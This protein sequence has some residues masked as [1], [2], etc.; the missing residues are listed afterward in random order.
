MTRQYTNKAMRSFFG[1]R[2]G[3]QDRPQDV[4]TPQ[5][6]IDAILRLWPDGIELDPCS[7]VES[8]V[9]ARHRVIGKGVWRW[10]SKG[11]RVIKTKLAKQNVFISSPKY[12]VNADGGLSIDWPDFTYANT[13]YD[14]LSQ[15]LSKPVPGRE[16]LM[17]CP[18]RPNRT[19]YCEAI[20]GDSCFPISCFLR[21]FAYDG[22]TQPYPTPVAIH[23]WGHRRKNFKAIFSVY[24]SIGKLIIE[25]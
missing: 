4:N 1:A 8:R 10:E 3:G 5:F 20:G 25:L 14:T 19:W 13:P 24:G 22:H 2:P 17:L 18:C 23:Y 9:P 6:L 21:P 16:H 15:W 12:P 7:N 11:K